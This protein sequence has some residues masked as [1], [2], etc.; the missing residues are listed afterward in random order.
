LQSPV[1]APFQAVKRIVAQ[2]VPGK[3]NSGTS[4]IVQLDPI[5]HI[6]ILIKKGGLIRSH[7]LVDHDLLAEADRW[8]VHQHE[9]TIGFH[10][11]SPG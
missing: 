8:E 11:H 6:S 7:D 1:E 10:E 4:R 2:A 3:V 9:Q 5:G